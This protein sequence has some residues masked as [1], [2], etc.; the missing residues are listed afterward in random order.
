MPNRVLSEA[1][2]LIPHRL[3]TQ[4][5]AAERV[6]DALREQIVD[7]SLRSGTR[8]TEETISAA[9]GF[10]RNT[11]REAFV[12]LIS[13]RLAAREPNRGVFVATPTADDIHDLYATRLLVEPSALEYG[14]GWSDDTPAE[15]RQIVETARTAQ[16]QGDTAGIAQANQDFHRA[17]TRLGQSRRVDHLMA[18]VLA[19]MRLVFHLMDSEEGFHEPYLERNDE[20]VRLLER[21]DRSA[22]AASLRGYLLDAE[23]QVLRHT[24]PPSAR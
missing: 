4:P 11:I 23:Q 16:E 13:E 8:L 14:S 20:I 12:L 22:A 9:L 19:E 10:S 2:R 18:G 21:G 17:I 5:S 7:G 15:L 1:L 6:A 24:L 3:P